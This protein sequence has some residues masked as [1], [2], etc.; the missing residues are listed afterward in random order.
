MITKIP[1]EF[2]CIDMHNHISQGPDGKLNR[3]MAQELLDGATRLGIQR[4]GVSRPSTEETVEPSKFRRM[5]DRVVE[6]MEM[7]ERFVGF[8]FVDPH[9]P[10]EAAAEIE[11]C[12]V[13]HG[14]AGIKLYHQFFICDDAQKPIMDKAAELGV[15]VLMHAGKCTDPAT[16]AA[17]PRLSHAG[18]FLE[19]LKKFPA[20]MLIQAHIGGGGDWEWNL[21]MLEGI[22]SDHYFIDISGSVI[23][24][25]I[26]RRTIETVGV[27]RVLFA[28]DMSLEEGVGKLLAAR[29]SHEELMKICSG[30]WNRIAGR[31]RV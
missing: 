7:S 21:R 16:I 30:N 10:D 17:Q 5:N 3:S 9:F 25:G 6:A 12:V 27:D 19:A 23:D 22:D 26:V 31:R 4:I 29:P 24:A 11:R 18:H 14:M 13:R 8:C 2:C 28:T 15:P 20:T 1:D